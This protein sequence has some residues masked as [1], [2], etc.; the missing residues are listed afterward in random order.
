MSAALSIAAYTRISPA[1]PEMAALMA[2]LRGALS[3][4]RGPRVGAALP[5]PPALAALDAKAQA[6]AEMEM[7]LA[8]IEPTNEFA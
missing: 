5:F 6:V 8:A 1:P 2:A 3:D 7:R 4:A